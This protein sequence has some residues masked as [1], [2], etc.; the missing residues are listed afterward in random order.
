MNFAEFKAKVQA[1]K[2]GKI[3]NSSFI[4]RWQRGLSV[5]LSWL[6]VKIWPQILPNYLSIFNVI[7]LWLLFLV[8]LFLP[9]EILPWVIL[10]QLFLL[11]FTSVLDKM[12]GEI[13]RYKDYFTQTGLYFDL[14]YHFS[15]AFIFYLTLGYYFAYLSNNLSIL[16]LSILVGLLSAIY[17]ML[18]KI[19]HHIKYKISLEGH[20]SEIKDW[21]VISFKKPRS[22]FFTL[23]DYG[24]LFVYDWVW[25]IYILCW[26]LSMFNWALATSLFVTHLLLTA[27]RLI[28]E[29]LWLYPRNN[30][31]TWPD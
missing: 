25:L 10:G 9:I 27:I 22:K 24:L 26:A 29:I 16:W 8:V 17:H 3:K 23:V 2:E 28:A 6:L 11:G 21:L 30:L 13:A 18:G 12:D 4:Y 15:Y 5:F 14:V 31:F 1:G 7:L 20:L 19:R